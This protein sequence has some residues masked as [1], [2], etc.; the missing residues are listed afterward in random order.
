MFPYGVCHWIHDVY[1]RMGNS[2]Q[3]CTV[4]LHVFHNELIKQ[5]YLAFSAHHPHN[6]QDFLHSGTALWPVRWYSS[7]AYC[8]R[9]HCLKPMPTTF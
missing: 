7:C 3:V 8:E 4:I 6:N 9:S 5:S 1:H 2:S